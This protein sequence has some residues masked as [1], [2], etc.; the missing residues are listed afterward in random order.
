MREEEKLCAELWNYLA[1]RF[2][3]D[4]VRRQKTSLKTE[5]FW[6]REVMGSCESAP[7]EDAG[8]RCV[9]SGPLRCRPLVRRGP[10]LLVGGECGTILHKD[11]SLASKMIRRLQ[12]LRLLRCRHRCELDVLCVEE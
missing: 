9:R 3:R 6:K 2:I 11:D 4:K 7:K 8:Q 5:T 10:V 12:M 1:R